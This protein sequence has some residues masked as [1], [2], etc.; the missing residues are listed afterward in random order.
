MTNTKELRRKIDASGLKM[1]FIAEKCNLT[2][3]G[4]LNKVDGRSQFRQSEITAIAAVLRLT[5]QE[6]FDIFFA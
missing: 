2:L 5:K 1:V 6:I 3:Q 4:L